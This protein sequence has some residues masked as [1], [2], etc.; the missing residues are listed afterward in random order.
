M[1]GRIILIIFIQVFSLVIYAQ[2]GLNYP[3]LTELGSSGSPTAKVY[4]LNY[5]SPDTIIDSIIHNDPFQYDPAR[6][7]TIIG[8]L[9]PGYIGGEILNTVFDGRTEVGFEIGH[10]AYDAYK[11]DIDTV[12]FFKRRVPY[13]HLL[14]AQGNTQTKTQTEADFGASFKDQLLSI[15]Y[16]RLYNQ[17]DF[18]NQNALH[19]AVYLGYLIQKDKWELGFIFGSN[20]I[21]DRYN[22]GIETDTLFGEGLSGIATNIPVRSSTIEGRH[23]E[24]NYL[25]KFDYL[26]P[27]LP[28]FERIRIQTK[29]ENQ[30]VKIF[31]TQPDSSIYPA[32]FIRPVGLRQF[33]QKSDW[34]NK[35]SLLSSTSTPF[36][37]EAGLK[38]HWIQL[39]QE[40]IETAFSAY[41]IFGNLNWAI[42]KNLSLIG[43]ARYGF[44][45]DQAEYS[46]FGKVHWRTKFFHL[47]GKYRNAST[48]PDLINRRMILLNEE[49]YNTDFTRT[50]QNHIGGKIF[51][52]HLALSF[53]A[54][55]QSM[56]NYRFWSRT[57]IIP[58]LADF[59]LLQISANHSLEL[60]PIMFNNTVIYQN[61]DKSI[62]PLPDWQGLHQLFVRTNILRKTLEV[63]LGTE[64]RYYLNYEPASFN[65][66]L[67]QFTVSNDQP[68]L[69][70]PYT[71]DFISKVRIDN[72]HFLF[73]F[74]N[75]QE[76]WEDGRFYSHYRTPF[77]APAFRLG[78]QWR[79]KG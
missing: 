49:L 30:Y 16:R 68:F 41:Y 51:F 65:P 40:P 62:L 47:S 59:T 42:T 11:F 38:F 77:P 48:I 37:L 74:E 4:P 78:L 1:I 60:G 52:P 18:Q 13:T 19:T 7:N 61:R 9:S 6:R 22:G 24:R 73:R 14:Y 5:H 26:L 10:D 12:P 56:F 23:Q 8:N 76:F 46:I 79:L 32:D 67:G 55:L 71:L 34:G 28:V 25:L 54:D 31:D 58:E 3:S 15:G 69:S 63:S 20:V 44:Q 17:G 36:Q 45:Q 2:D 66:F 57:A 50:I 64:L 70:Y 21:Q 53:K 29:L 33:I 39:N 27:F 43:N 35:F 75:L 72:F